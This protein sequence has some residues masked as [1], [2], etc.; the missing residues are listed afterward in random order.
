MDTGRAY[1]VPKKIFITYIKADP[2]C[3]NLS[4]LVW[5]LFAVAF[6][7]NQ[8]LTRIFFNTV[9]EGAKF[10]F[11][12]FRFSESHHRAVKAV[13]SFITEQSSSSIS[14]LGRNDLICRRTTASTTTASRSSGT[15]PERGSAAG[16]ERGLPRPP[17]PP[18]V[19]SCSS[20]R[21]EPARRAWRHRPCGFCGG[22]QGQA[23]VELA[24]AGAVA[25]AAEL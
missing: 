11:L 14:A 8:M 6:L 5:Q 3:S 16:D 18:A 2:F 21:D 17:A 1:K 25:G 10:R 13:G 15:S 9:E 12:S 20:S 24:L 7:S 22:R 19:S 23:W 4:V